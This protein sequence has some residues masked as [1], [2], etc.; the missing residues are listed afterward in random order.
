MVQG[1]SAYPYGMKHFHPSAPR[2]TLVFA[3]GKDLMS[4]SFQFRFLLITLAYHALDSW[5]CS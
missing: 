4:L 2:A 1:T 3:H 5:L